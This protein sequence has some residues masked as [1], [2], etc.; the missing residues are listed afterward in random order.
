MKY[1]FHVRFIEAFREIWKFWKSI[2][3]IFSTVKDFPIEFVF[4]L[5]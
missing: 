4:M 2:F 5:D 1:V 3:R